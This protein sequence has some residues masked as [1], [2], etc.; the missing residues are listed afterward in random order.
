MS[1]HM[2][3][4]VPP[5]FGI[6]PYILIFL[7]LSVS[8]TSR[9]FTVPQRKTLLRRKLQSRTGI[10]DF[11]LEMQAESE[12][13]RKAIAQERAAREHLEMQFDGNTIQFR[14]VSLHI[15]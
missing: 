15:H 8:P 11:L 3:G 12:A 5:N 4:A 2:A 10:E 6:I 13:L 14:F 7:S 1:A 9:I